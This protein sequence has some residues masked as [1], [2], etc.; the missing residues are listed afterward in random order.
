MLR[1]SWP[2]ALQCAALVDGLR[3]L[4][5]PAVEAAPPVGAPRG[6]GR[7]SSRVVSHTPRPFRLACTPP[8]PCYGSPSPRRRS[9]PASSRRP[10]LASHRGRRIDAPPPLSCGWPCTHWRVPG[11]AG[12]RHHVESREGRAVA[13]LHKH[14]V[15]SPAE[16]RASSTPPS[17]SHAELVAPPTAPHAG[18]SR[19]QRE[20][21]REEGGVGAAWRELGRREEGG[22]G[23]APTNSPE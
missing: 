21:G 18:S 5:S 15:A 10:P 14:Q 1:R 20:L 23:A 4:R 9:C 16:L 12:G 8:L 3:H 19:R 2:A 11:T 22:G 13:K 7:S 6:S 17:L